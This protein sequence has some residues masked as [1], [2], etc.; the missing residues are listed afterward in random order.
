MQ[1]LAA[2][3]AMRVWWLMMFSIAVSSSWASMMGAV[4]RTKGS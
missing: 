3:E 4:T 1:T 2:L